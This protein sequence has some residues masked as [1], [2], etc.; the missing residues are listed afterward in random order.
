MTEAEALRLL[1]KANTR[2]FTPTDYDAFSGV[3]GPD[4][5]IGE[6]GGY[7]IIVDENQ[8]SFVNE[9]GEETTFHLT[10]TSH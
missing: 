3:E 10:K 8:V 6:A 4:P 9:E 5:R 2:P 7:V 1:L